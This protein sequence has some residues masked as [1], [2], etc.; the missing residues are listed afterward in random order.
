MNQAETA[1]TGL[2]VPR[3]LIAVIV[4]ALAL[5]LIPIAASAVETMTYERSH[6]VEKHGLSTAESI[7]N[8]INKN[9]PMQTWQNPANGRQALVC[10]IS[11]GKFGIQ[12]R[13]S[14]DGSAWEEITAFVKEKFTRISQVEQYLRNTGYTCLDCAP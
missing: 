5:L 6:A 10:E 1:N 2:N 9:G 3:L 13:Q 14:K 7:R 12:V 4:I 8:C 11:P